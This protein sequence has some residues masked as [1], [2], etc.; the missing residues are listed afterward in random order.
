MAKKRTINE[1]RQ[2]KDAVYTHPRSKPKHNWNGEKI[3]LVDVEDQEAA[4]Q[5]AEIDYQEWADK[6]NS[7][8]EMKQNRCPLDLVEEAKILIVDKITK[9]F[10]DIMFE[11]ITEEMM[12]YRVFQSQNYLT[13]EGYELF[14]DEYFEF[15]HEHHGDI[16]HQVMKK[17]TN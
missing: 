9:H 14:E 5:M 13:E 3:T 11:T 4:K 8:E 12:D 6:A 7:S 10:H 15:Y 17:I 16:L 2:T 1:I